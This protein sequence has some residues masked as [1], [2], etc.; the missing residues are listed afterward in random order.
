MKLYE[1]TSRT[2]HVVAARKSA[3][4]FFSTNARGARLAV[5]TIVSREL[6]LSSTE[7]VEP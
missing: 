3:S 7:S 2:L 6:Q 4:D 1:D 5:L